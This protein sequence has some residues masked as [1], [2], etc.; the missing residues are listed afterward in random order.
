MKQ[1][2]NPPYDTTNS[3]NPWLMNNKS[4]PPIIGPEGL[5]L[6]AEYIWGKSG[7]DR[8]DLLEWVFKYYREK[9]F[10]LFKLTDAEL[11]KEFEALKSKNSNDVF[12]NG[13][14]KNSNTVGLD[15]AKHF[16]S[17]LFF[18]SKGGP[19]TKSCIEVFNDDVLLKEVLKNRM[20]FCVSREDGNTRPYV[21]AINDQ[22]LL[23]GTRSSGYGYSVSLFKPLI[24]KYIYE[25]Y[26]VKK[27]LDYSIG[28]NARCIAALS[29]GIEYYGIDPLTADRTNEM[30]KY[31]GGTGDCISGCSEK[32]DYSIFPNV[33]LCFSSP[34]YFDLETYSNDPTQS[35]QY[36]A[37]TDWLELYWRETVKKCYDKCKFFSFLAVEKVRKY[38]LLAD[39]SRICLEEG[40]VLVEDIPIKTSL[41]HLS[42]KSKSKKVDKKTEHV[43]VFK[44]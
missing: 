16:T 14:I 18:A 6:T 17:D 34:P 8:I 30:I 20:G 38:D 5:P 36:K 12:E 4:H 35:S 40:G 22:M 31:F 25:K 27:T 15:I 41:N 33:D 39:M 19:K 9:G 24:A 1:K 44:V 10:P 28:W 42:G 23:Q 32:L 3:T 21:F 37:Y 7:Q 29:L 13:V 26:N 2:T 43:V 11:K